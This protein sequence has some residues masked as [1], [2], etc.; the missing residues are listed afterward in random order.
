M[1]LKTNL[2]VEPRITSAPNSFNISGLLLSL[3]LGFMLLGPIQAA[4][5][6]QAADLVKS[7]T[8]RL[9][10]ELQRRRSEIKTNPNLVYELAEIAVPHFD[11]YRIT[12][13]AVGHYWRKA[14]SQQR[15]TLI[16][17]FRTLLIN[18]Y[19]KALRNYSGQEIVLL[20][21]RRSSRRDRTVVRTQ[22]KM[23]SRNTVIPI[24]Y[25]MRLRRGSWKVYDV[26]IEGVSLVKNY[27][28]SFAQEVRRGGI[29]GLI[30]KLQDRNRNNR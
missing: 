26:T 21:S 16:A 25:Y 27:R 2:K 23:P 29:Q 10:S 8:D 17:E 24:N 7:T 14:N 28:K 5:P 18:T 11:F 9:L 13:L 19:G 20:P 6:R 1:N 22:V 12:Q 3:V 30:E 15:K 4:T